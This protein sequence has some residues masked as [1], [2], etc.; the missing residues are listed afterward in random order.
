MSLCCWCVS[1]CSFVSQ[2]YS[3]TQ[4]LVYLQGES[5]KIMSR[6]QVHL[7]WNFVPVFMS[8]QSASFTR[9]CL[10]TISYCTSICALDSQV[11][12]PLPTPVVCRCLSSCRSPQ[13][14]RS[15]SLQKLWRPLSLKSL[16]SRMESCWLS[17][18]NPHHSCWRV[19]P[20]LFVSMPVVLWPKML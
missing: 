12:A 3:I 6:F 10:K 9:F 19:H 15:V 16:G 1:N 7:F 4:V 11:S 18:L 13:A 2:F 5:A 14:H 17:I 8:G 20:S